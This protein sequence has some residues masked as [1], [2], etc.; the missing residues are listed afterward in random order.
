MEMLNI[1]A[2]K[3]DMFK[4]EQG[5][6]FANQVLGNT[7]TYNNPFAGTLIDNIFSFNR[8]KR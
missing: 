4:G 3:P 5:Q 7:G 8:Y 2:S 1:M 6:M